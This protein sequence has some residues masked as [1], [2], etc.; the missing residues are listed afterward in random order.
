MSSTSQAPP[1]ITVEV[2]NKPLPLPMRLAS[3]RARPGPRTC[4]RSMPG[5]TPVLPVVGLAGM[6]LTMR[7]RR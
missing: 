2:P 7:R 1:T 5:L 3:L 6:A 4:R